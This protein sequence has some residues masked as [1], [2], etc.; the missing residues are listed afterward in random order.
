[1]L[2]KRVVA[3]LSQSTSAS[4]LSMASFFGG[5]RSIHLQ[6]NSFNGPFRQDPVE[7]IVCRGQEGETALEI[8]KQ[9]LELIQS[10]RNT[11]VF[12]TVKS[13]VLRKP[14]LLERREGMHFVSLTDQEIADPMKI[15]SLA[16][17]GVLFPHAGHTCMAIVGAD[18]MIQNEVSLRPGKGGKLVKGA[19]TL[20]PSLYRNKLPGSVVEAY[21]E[22]FPNEV[23][24][25]SRILEE[26][27]KTNGLSDLAVDITFVPLSRSVI[28]IETILENIKA[29]QSI[30]LYNMCT[31]SVKQVDIDNMTDE[32]LRQ[33]VEALKR[34]SEQPG[35]EEFRDAV[36]NPDAE[37]TLRAMACTNGIITSATGDPYDLE[38]RIGSDIDV[39]RAVVYSVI[40]LIGITRFLDFAKEIKFYDEVSEL[41]TSSMEL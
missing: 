12:L 29:A 13:G 41:T 5:K 14:S 26:S 33:S 38:N 9:M 3:R 28:P 11:I 2:R 16:R 19:A 15:S 30:K 39:Q 17:Q 27:K 22:A 7:H 21:H 18:G 20:Y 36:A 32:S 40:S 31:L 25:F 37:A 35:F 4:S 1:M 24:T 23:A 8:E 34:C 6:T 10:K